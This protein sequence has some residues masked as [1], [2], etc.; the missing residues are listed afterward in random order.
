M[1]D[2]T[3]EDTADQLGVSVGELMRGLETGR[4]S[5][6]VTKDDI[7]K[8][9]KGDPQF[10]RVRDLRAMSICGPDYE[11]VATDMSTV[12]EMPEMGKEE[13]RK[14]RD[15]EVHTTL[16]TTSTDAPDT[17]STDVPDTTSTGESA[18]QSTGT[19][20]PAPVRPEEDQQPQTSGDTSGDVIGTVLTY[21]AVAAGGAALLGALFGEDNSGPTERQLRAIYTQGWNA[22][23]EAQTGNP[24]L[25]N[26]EMAEA[27]RQGWWD[28][29][30]RITAQM[31]TTNGNARPS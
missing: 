19:D 14:N 26:P 10:F 22:R 9:D 1:V 11:D 27:Y 18:V 5:E 12:E 13:T 29:D 30:E 31:L 17:T 3:L 8:S 21:A 7:V 4:F 25:G 28:A 16:A 20:A 23:A 6:Y 15:P 24:Y 2:L